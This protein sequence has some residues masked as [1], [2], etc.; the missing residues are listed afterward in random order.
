MT[1][2]HLLGAKARIFSN[3]MLHQNG[4]RLRIVAF[5]AFN[6]LF[7]IAIYGV[8]YWFFAQCLMV[9]PIGEIV[10]RRMLGMA[11][12]TMFSLLSFSC[13]VDAFSTL[14]LAHDLELLVSRPIP[15]YSLYI[16]RWVETAVHASWMIVPFS[17]PIFISAGLLFDA[18]WR[19]AMSLVVVYTALVVI[20]TSL[21]VSLSL[22]LTSALSARRARL[23][24]VIAGSIAAGIVA[25]IIRSLRPE[26]F[27][28]PDQR[29]PLL[30]ALEA[31]HGADAPW[32][33]STWALSA[34]WPHLGY[35]SETRA[36]PI[37]LL[38]ATS[39]TCFFIGGWLFRV[40]YP[41]A[42]S[43]AQEGVRRIGERQGAG[44]GQKRSRSLDDLV[45]KTA[46]DDRKMPFAGH[47]AT[48]DRLVFARD[49]AQWSQVLILA[50][51]G[52][53]YILNFKYIRAITGTGLVPDLGLYFLNL[54]LTGF[55]CLAL[56]VR[57]AFP[58]VS[59]EGPAFWLVRSS[60]NTV[61][62]FLRAKARSLGIPLVLFSNLLMVT[63][64]LFLDA[65]R[66]LLIAAVIT[67][68]PAVFGLV[69]L[70][71]GLGARYPRFRID[72][73]TAIATGVGGVV[74][75]LTGA[76]VLVIVVGLSI[77]PTATFMHCIDH[78]HWPRS[79]QSGFLATLSLFAAIVFPLLVGAWSLRSGARH[80]ENLEQI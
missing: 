44:P 26:Q 6:L 42:Y 23:L 35:G 62:A 32:L 31:L 68:T 19:Y 37:L 34:I 41:R 72:N 53:I 21:G 22:I 48:K 77:Y 67:V 47:L 7:I 52:A 33:P 16:A 55:V 76:F 75:M 25:F 40:L 63:T 24:L 43:K 12:L 20:P 46:N 18:N 9:E 11:L 74:F 54:G 38:L 65:A 29:A 57:F 14:Y 80:L 30:E 10:I 73:A 5:S 3:S 69:C 27:M 61:S 71:V 60:P 1:S 2:L 4:G 8:S 66:P 39:A 28:N 51:V 56:A 13:L 36:H 70:G 50:A 78:G 49:T 45:L 58:S 15:A 17:L 79:F 59:L 64:H